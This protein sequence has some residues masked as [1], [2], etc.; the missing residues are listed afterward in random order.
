M[1]FSCQYRYIH[2]SST[3]GGT[4]RICPRFYRS[5]S[6]RS[7]LEFSRNFVETEFPEQVRV[8]TIVFG[9]SNILIDGL[10]VRIA[11]LECTRTDNRGLSTRSG[12]NLSILNSVRTPSDVSL[13]CVISQS[14]F[15]LTEKFYQRCTLPMGQYPSSLLC[16]DEIDIIMSL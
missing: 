9:T 16:T 2:G 8:T 1:E 14:T 3:T 15:W 4:P 7:P 13:S 12:L 5:L 11:R 10:L 6:G